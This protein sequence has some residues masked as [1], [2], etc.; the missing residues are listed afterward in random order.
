MDPAERWGRVVDYSA[1]CQEIPSSF[2][3][4]VPRNNRRAASLDMSSSAYEV[5]RD[6]PSSAYTAG[7]MKPLHVPVLLSCLGVTLMLA[8]CGG[9]SGDS[10]GGEGG[11]NPPVPAITSIAPT[12]VTA[13]S[14]SLTLTVNGTGFLTT[15]IV[16]VGK[17]SEATTYVNGTELT[18]I[19][20]GSQL[21]TG[22]QLTVTVMNG[23]VSSGSGS[24]VN[25]Q[26]MNPAP[27]IS[28]VSPS[29]VPLGAASPS[30]QVAKG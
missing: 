14:A 13:G 12:N 3:S 24:V 28:S 11:S 10:G 5:W 6:L 26:V 20:P 4:R 29:T 17:V 25:L 30:C 22:E 2:L 21:T 27:V 15:S 19:I 1:V 18:A 7:T 16:Q 9:S 8:G 23:S